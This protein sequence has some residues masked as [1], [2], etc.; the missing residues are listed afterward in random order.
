[1]TILCA[2]NRCTN[3][4]NIYCSCRKWNTNIAME[5]GRAWGVGWN[6]WINKQFIHR[7]V[8]GSSMDRGKGFA[9]GELGGGICWLKVRA[10]LVTGWGRF[11]LLMR[12]YYVT[13]ETWWDV[14]SDDVFHH[15]HHRHSSHTRAQLVVCTLN[16]TRCW[17]VGLWGVMGAFLNRCSIHTHIHSQMASGWVLIQNPSIPHLQCL[18]YPFT[19]VCKS[20]QSVDYIHYRAVSYIYEVCNMYGVTANV[21][22]Q[23]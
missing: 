17:W 21:Q 10:G 23:I 19:W 12:R 4:F 13:L 11:G 22:P 16:T 8:E 18:P 6:G 14:K 1:M 9:E 5:G 15:H 7:V 3:K 20:W 2:S